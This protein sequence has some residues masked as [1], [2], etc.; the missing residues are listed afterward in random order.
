MP[1]QQIAAIVSLIFSLSWAVM[2]FVEWSS[3]TDPDAP[4]PMMRIFLCVLFAVMAVT[5]WRG[6]P[7]GR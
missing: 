7:G 3:T 1:R 4:L 6:R 5:L 2:A